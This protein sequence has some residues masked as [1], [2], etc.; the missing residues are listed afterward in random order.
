MKRAKRSEPWSYM[1]GMLPHRVL[2][3]E[4]VG[5]KGIVY[6]R[7]RV[8]KEWVKKSLGFTVRATPGGRLDTSAV[9][10]AQREAEAWYNRLL[11]QGVMPALQAA[12]LTI[13]QGWDLAIDAE[14]GKW[15]ENTPHRKEMERAINRAKAVWGA[16]TP[17]NL[18]ERGDLR[19]LWR[20]E[21]RRVRALGKDG[22]RSA[23]IVIARVLALAAWLRD[24]QKIAP[25]AC[26]PW[27]SMKEEMA[28]DIGSYEPKR[29]RY[30]LPEFRAI[31]KT[32]P[33]IDE[34]WGLL[35]AL[36]AEYRL[37]QVT[38]CRRRDLNLDV[39]TLLIAGSGR[40]RGTTVQLTLGQLL[41]VQHALTVGYL[42]GLEEAYRK[43]TIADYPLFPGV[44]LPVKDGAIYTQAKHATRDHIENTP[45]RRWLRATE[46]QARVDG[47]PIPHVPGRGWYGLRRAGVDAAK[48]EGISREGLQQHGGWSDAQVPDAV[49]ADQKMGYAAE[50][51]AR[52]RAKI[53][54]EEPPSS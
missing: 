34:R 10:R 9:E 35:L 18:I 11:N 25:T 5:R 17:W 50:E 12:P 51:A 3:Y 43:Q 48:E 1:V 39:G 30:T 52:V 19:T 38:R 41:A 37:G 22:A 33:S 8:S 20:K 45:L 54:G 13:A 14:R 21:L 27:K 46:K 24:E 53:R 28:K 15:N 36:G 4:H 49:Y 40:K 44:K 7:W 2:A 23:Q 29:L 6:L 42:A 31:L 16:N 47:E 26:L 32:A